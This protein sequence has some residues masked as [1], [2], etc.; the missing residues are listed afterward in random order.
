MKRTGTAVWTGGIRDG[1]GK[2]AT[3]SGTLKDVAYSFGSRFENGSGTNPEELIAA[4]H[5]G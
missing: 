4:A 2:L 5:A 1:K 3:P